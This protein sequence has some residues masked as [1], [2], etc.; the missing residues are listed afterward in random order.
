[1]TERRRLLLVSHRPIDY[2]GGGSVR[3]RHLTQA[4]PRLGWD[5]ATVTARTNPTANE[6]SQDPVALR[7]VAARARLMNAVGDITR[8][9]AQ[10]RLGV[11]PE[12][13]GPN[14]AWSITGRRAIR[15]AIRRE[16]PDVVWATGPPQSA[17]LAGVPVAARLEIPVVA[18]LRDLWAGS[19]YFDAGG[20]LL[21]RLEAP[22][23]TRA[24]AVVTVTRGCQQILEQLHPKLRDRVHLVPNGFDSSLLGLRRP[25]RANHGV[26]TLIHAGAL[27]GD[28]FAATLIQALSV[29]ALRGRVQLELVGPVD[30][31]TRRAAANT[32]AVVRISPPTSWR[33]AIEHV[34]GAD[35]S[36]VINSP[37]TGGAMALPSK[38]YEALALGV[39]VLALT[40]PGSDAERLLAALG[41]DRGVCAPDDE[42]GIS[43]AVMRLLDDPPEPV[44][45]EQLWDYN[46]DVIASQIVDLLNSLV[47][48]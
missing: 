28:R 48:D 31:E 46:R 35:I 1:M 22:A 18:E 12:A 33:Q 7:L 15:S 10:R 24:D 8:S 20:T 27:Y 26:R 11:Q 14:L 38:L 32:D 40:P 41:Q 13:L 44:P 30:P 21:T 9:P 39:P 2:G 29:P 5:V 4:L 34:R 25:K 43:E 36:V 6:A 19:P 45:P 3:W 17:I 47:S 23:L 16:G 37:G 42:R